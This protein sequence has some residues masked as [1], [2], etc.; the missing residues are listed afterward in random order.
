MKTEYTIRTRTFPVTIKDM[1]TG[2]I[3]EDSIVLDKAQL[4]GVAEIG[5]DS[6][7]LIHRT[8]NRQGYKVLDIGTPEKRTITIDLAELYRLHSREAGT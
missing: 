5:M 8:Y 7:E 2:E 3:K 1:R 6:N 4:Q